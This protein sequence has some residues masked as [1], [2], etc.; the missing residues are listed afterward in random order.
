MLPFDRW[1]ERELDWLT[2]ALHLARGSRLRA[3]RLPPGSPDFYAE[4]YAREMSLEA[5]RLH[6]ANL[7][8]RGHALPPELAVMARAEGL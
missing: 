5:A 3:G 7:V 6:Q 4:E 2:M 8:R 1:R